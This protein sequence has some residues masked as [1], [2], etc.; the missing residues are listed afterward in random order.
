MLINIRTSEA[1]KP[2]VQD[3][4]RRLNLG[5]ENIISRIA[6]AYSISK[7]VK[8]NLEVDL[9]DSKGK[10]YK[11]DILFGKYRD[12]YIAMICQHYNLYK[13]DKDIGK[14]IK[15]HID[16][17]L[18]LMNKLFEENKNY[19]GLDFLLENIERGIEKL[20][21][22]DVTMDAIIFDEQTRR[23][24]VANKDYFSDPIKI[25]VGQT[26]DGEDIYFR[27]NDTS[28]HN[29]AHIAVAGNSGTG[30][31]YFAN[32][33]LKQI[34]KETNGEVNFIFLDFK[35]ISEEDEK[36]NSDFFTKTNTELIKAP[37][38]PFP[39]NP[40]SFIDNV[41][42]KNK[43]MGISKFVDIITSYSNIGKNQQQT[44]KDATREVFGSMK[45]GQYPSFKQI[46]DTVI[47]IE[48]EKASTLKEILQSL[49]ELDLF[50]TQA[51]LKNSFLNRNYYLSLSGDLPRNV[52][53]TS[54]FLIIN[55]IYNTFMNMD[56]A[57]IEGDYQGMRYV[58]LIDEAHTIF[59]EKKSQ[60][61]LEKILREIRSKGV[62]VVLLSQG[63][64]EF[65]QPSFD[66]SSM[67]ETA[68]LFDIKDK[69]NLKMMQKFLGIGDKD[70][71]KLKNSMEKIEKYQL[72]SNLKEYK[73]AELFKA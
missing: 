13:S 44:L 45:G 52:R 2:V 15:M 46:Y 33:I 53:F 27:F 42:E 11:D 7:G 10:E 65:N 62:S 40:L 57:P 26:F 70:G 50:E 16:H 25:R 35:G 37:Y 73:V 14:Y 49:S 19:S 39:I 58:F 18:L 59:K 1:N 34:V 67:C 66:F 22:N 38:K 9:F 32:S 31:T 63:I 23:S 4:T 51:D 72:V 43:I 60:D 5:T 41:N 8:L 24:R 21:E 6:F 28:I 30:K 12:Y 56:N 48:G 69:T 64:E 47:D 3:L 61:L 68:F 36:K 55:Y 54:V 29:N 20:E 17:G 71:Q